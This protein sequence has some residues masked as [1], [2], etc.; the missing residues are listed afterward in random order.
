MS[1]FLGGGSVRRHNDRLGAQAAK[2]KKMGTRINFMI[3]A[4]SFDLE[5]SG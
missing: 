3:V 2:R 1:V 5:R 4:I